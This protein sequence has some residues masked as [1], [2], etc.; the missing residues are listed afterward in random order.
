MQ[1]EGNIADFITYFKALTL[2]D[3]D[4]QF[5]IYG[6]VELGIDR[7][8]GDA[9][10]K[11]PLMWLEQP[12]VQLTGNEQGQWNNKFSCGISIITAAKLDS[13]EDQEEKSAECFEITG[14]IINALVEDSK[15]WKM[16]SLPKNFEMDEVDRGWA[17][18]HVGWRI[19]FEMHMVARNW[20]I[21]N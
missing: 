20:M 1:I 6:G 9:N 17:L 15:D 12:R 2:A 3:A 11:Y 18:N 10:Y 19:S 7:A 8:Q 13:F 5:F 21:G 14:R 16:V 4:L